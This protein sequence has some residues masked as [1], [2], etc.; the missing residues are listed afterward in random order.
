[1][2]TW[3]H[4]KMTK[5]TVCSLADLVI[6]PIFFLFNPFRDFRGDLYVL[7]YL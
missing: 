3:R 4:I 5:K 2:I 7:L 1:M 6:F